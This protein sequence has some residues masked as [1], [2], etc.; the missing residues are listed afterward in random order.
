VLQRLA[1]ARRR[2]RTAARPPTAAQAQSL[3]LVG[4][5]KQLPPTVKCRAA[6]RLGLGS[7]LFVRLQAM[8]LEPLLLDTQ[9]RM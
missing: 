7:S 8:G 6:E 1:P 5:Q 3:L 4:D 9:Y 2:A